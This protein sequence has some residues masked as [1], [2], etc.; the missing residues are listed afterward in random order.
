MTSMPSVSVVIAV[1]NG[2]KYLAQAIESALAQSFP[3]SEIIVIDDGSKDGTPGVINDYKKKGV[4]ISQRVEPNTGVANGMNTGMTMA[5]GKYIAFLDHDDVWFRD[6]L[7]KQVEA[8]ERYPEAGL[9]CCNFAHRPESL[10]RRVFHFSKLNFAKS[11]DFKDSVMRQPF[12]TMVKESIIGTSSV[13]LLRRSIAQQVG[14]FNRKYRVS[15]DYDY[16]MRCSLVAPFVVLKDALL[17][18]RTHATNISADRIFTFTEYRQILRELPMEIQKTGRNKTW[19]ALC[20]QEAANI[21]YML[22]NLCFE[23]GEK[24]KTFEFF[25]QGFQE[26]KTFANLFVYGMLTLKKRIRS[27]RG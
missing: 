26:N 11:F 24:V 19:E 2:E 5:T 14:L 16:W 27:L 13:V 1:Y 6:K 8:M 15:G 21:S 4:V 22:G 7:K 25:D 12:L 9:A 20:R 3:P 17:Y 18:K 10:K 23:R